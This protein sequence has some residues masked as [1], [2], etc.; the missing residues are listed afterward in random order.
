MVK[1]TQQIG[2][3]LRIDQVDWLKD[4]PRSFNLSQV[5]RELLDGYIASKQVLQVGEKDVSSSQDN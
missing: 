5:V 3:Y 2:V 4:Q 1:N